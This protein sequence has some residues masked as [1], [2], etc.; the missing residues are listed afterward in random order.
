[1]LRLSV[2][3]ASPST[4]VALRQ[5]KIG[6][7]NIRTSE[8]RNRLLFA[9]HVVY[10]HKRDAAGGRHQWADAIQLGTTPLREPHS[11][12]VIEIDQIALLQLKY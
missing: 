1:V 10:R 4:D 7:P 3:V 6:E 2:P 9:V 12:L 5:A 8:N 11:A